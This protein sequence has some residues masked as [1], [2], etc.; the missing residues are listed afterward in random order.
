MVRRGPRLVLGPLFRGSLL[1]ALQAM[2]SRF[3]M[4]SLLILLLPLAAG[5]DGRVWRAR[6][7]DHPITDSLNAAPRT[8]VVIE[9]HVGPSDPAAAGRLERFIDRYARRRSLATI[10]RLDGS[11]E[12]TLGLV[13]DIALAPD[14]Q[15]VFVLDRT[16]SD[17]TVY[18]LDGRYLY[19]FGGP[20]DGP[21][22]FRIPEAVV[23]VSQD[24]LLVPDRFERIH[25]FARDRNGKFVYL[26]REAIGTFPRD[27]CA[28]RPGFILH[29]VSGGQ[30][31]VLY[32][33]DEKG[34]SKG[35]FA[36][37][38]RYSH[39]RPRS[40]VSR[41]QVVCSQDLG[42]VILAFYARDAV[43][44]Y[45]VGDGTL[46]WHSK[47]NGML[48]SRIV[49]VEGG[50]GVL[51]G[52]FDS[53]AVHSLARAS[54]GSNS[55]VVLQYRKVLRDDFIA[56]NREHILETYLLD[57][58]T[59]EGLYLGDS[60]PLVMYLYDD[61]LVTLESDP[62]PKLEIFELPTVTGTPRGG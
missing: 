49:E 21:G 30:P 9:R 19:S 33:Y 52:V 50:S 3:R 8:A 62:Y 57:P 35:G 36:V 18:G 28:M 56:R 34:N 13:S 27:A 20:G 24:R 29:A 53:P 39:Y 48:P 43:E 38:Y 44:A 51:T 26:N 37:P 6:E 41:G 14:G 58:V 59:G 7:I 2:R 46:A 61:L 22:E 32:R 15:E 11:I 40:M 55:P 5:C 1:P 10:G 4:R 23:F 42:L 54:G 60:I 12:E 16:A 17:V 25:R 45:H 31:E 47:L